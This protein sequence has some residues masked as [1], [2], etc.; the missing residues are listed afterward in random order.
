MN[1]RRYLF[2]VISFLV[3]A[4]V[5]LFIYQK[6]QL[7]GEA[8]IELSPASLSKPYNSE[9]IQPLPLEIKLPEEKVHLG[10]LLFNETRLSKDNSISC[11]SCHLLSKAGTDGIALAIGINAAIGQLNTP[12]VFNSFFNFVQFWD[13]RVTTLEEQAV[14]P[15]HNPIEMNS[16]W[17]EILPKLQAD[18]QYPDLFKA[19]YPDGITSGNIINAIA[20]YEASL[21]T[22]NSRF[23]QY[24]RGNKDIL[25]ENELKGYQ[26]FKDYGCISCHQGINIGGNMF[27]RF[28]IF[29][30]YFN[31]KQI[32]QSDLGRF[33]VTEL[34]EDR[35]V[36]KVPGLRNI[37]VTAPYFHDGSAAT[38]ENAVII[39]GLHQLGRQLSEE[40][41]QFLVA[42]LQTLTGEWQGKILQ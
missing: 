42:F 26:L 2:P 13:G 20:T 16:N 22:P 4:G 33:N 1:S 19:L 36:F 9:Q 35:H 5:L 8:L 18:K 12:T 32:N 21:I 37:A 39:M 31:N 29:E 15:I 25:T 17:L 38:L 7:S 3:L 30:G 41:V 11:A 40:D 34:E 28:G 27:Q 24:L 10:Q 23:D 14:G 6:N